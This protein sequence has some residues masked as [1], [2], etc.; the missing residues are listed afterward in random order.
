MV[1][2]QGFFKV[3]AP[4]VL[5]VLRIVTAL[6][7][8]VHGTAKLLQMPHQALRSFYR[9]IWRLHTSW[10]IGRK[11]GCRFSTAANSL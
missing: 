9:A 4:R 11:A 1:T 10:H 8:M 3:W 5:S 7:F 6:L 2:D